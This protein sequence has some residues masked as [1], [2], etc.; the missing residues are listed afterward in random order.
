MKNKG[1]NYFFHGSTAISIFGYGCYWMYLCSGEHWRRS[2]G[3]Q[4]LIL[5]L[6]FLTFVFISLVFFCR[7]H[8]RHYIAFA[9]LSLIPGIIVCFINRALRYQDFE[10]LIETFSNSHPNDAVSIGYKS[11]YSEL[12]LQYDY[13]VSRSSTSALIMGILQFIWI[14]LLIQKI[15]SNQSKQ[16]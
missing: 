5:I 9:F 7:N 4:N 8:K 6:F 2:I 15:I 1:I 11:I 16:K 14:I 3:P 10:N 12:F 13:I